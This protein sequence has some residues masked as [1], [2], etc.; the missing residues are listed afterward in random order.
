MR[1]YVC[2]LGL[3]GTLSAYA[4]IFPTPASRIVRGSGAPASSACDAAAEV[5]KVYVRQDTAAEKASLYICANTAAMTYAWELSSGVSSLSQLPS[6]ADQRILGNVSGG[7]AAPS[8]LT[9]SQLKSNFGLPGLADAN[10][11]TANQTIQATYGSNSAPAITSTDYTVGSGWAAVSGGVLNK[12]A[13]G[14]GTAAWTSG[15]TNIVAG[16]TYKVILT[17]S[18]FT[19]GSATVSLGCS[20]SGA[21]ACTTSKT[22]NAAQTYTLFFYAADTSKITITPTNTSR[23]TISALSI[24][25]ATAVTGMLT[26]DG[27]PMWNGFSMSP[28]SDGQTDAFYGFPYVTANGQW[29]I[30]PLSGYTPCLNAPCSNGGQLV[31]G[32]GNSSAFN[33]IFGNNNASHRVQLGAAGYLRDRIGEFTLCDNNVGTFCTIAGM[34]GI[35]LN[36]A[37]GTTVQTNAHLVSTGTLPTV[38]SGFGTSPTLETGST[39]LSG[40]ITVGTGG[41]TAGVITFATAFARAPSVACQNETSAALVKC[42]ASTTTLTFAGTFT[43]ADK[44]TWVA[45]GH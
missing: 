1:K 13:D 3:L 14:T 6:I 45:L 2:L 20:L 36:P 33:I 34:S 40:R 19:A 28:R 8:E 12:N 42:T 15:G 24:L 30:D 38:T 26:S 39:D 4:Q 41:D 35:K 43:A 7:S 23:F 18:A 5:G 9:A 37:A 16:T 31:L 10:A 27:N 21:N 25:P 44:L 29:A 32:W 11:F 17:T 22:I